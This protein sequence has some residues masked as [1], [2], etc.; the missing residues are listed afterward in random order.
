MV[1]VHKRTLRIVAEKASNLPSSGLT[2]LSDPYLVFEL[3]KQQCRTQVAHKTLDPTWREELELTILEDNDSSL[4]IITLYDHNIMQPDERLGQL[5]IDLKQY[6]HTSPSQGVKMEVFTCQLDQHVCP[7]YTIQ[8]DIV[9]GISMEIP[10][11]SSIWTRVWENQR[12]TPATGGWSKDNLIPILGD[13]KPWSS[14]SSEGDH[15]KDA[16]PVVPE[17]YKPKGAW[18]FNLSCC[19]LDGW[20][21]AASFSGPWHA[22]MWMS[23][24]VR[25]RQWVN[26]YQSTETNPFNNNNK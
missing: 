4:L 18:I 3:G 11:P 9:L 2:M 19:D 25:C 15:F 12:W 1:Q 14:N 5:V 22:S 7:S 13:R 21:Y 26:E 10:A 17:G 20:R 16:I 8:S 6:Y 23:D 24:V